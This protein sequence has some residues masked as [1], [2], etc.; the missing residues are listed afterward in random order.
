MQMA[1]LPSILTLI[2]RKRMM[3]FYLLIL[4]L[5]CTKME[6]VDMSEQKRD[7][8]SRTLTNAQIVFKDSGFIKINLRS[9]LIEEYALIDSPYTQF[10]KGLEMNFYSNNI[11]S[12][13]Y[14]RANWA[15]MNELK[16]WYEGRG[17]VK[18]I[19]EKGNRKSVV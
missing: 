5:G 16:E 6:D 19:S 8:P 18:I 17:D 2:C 9:P 13:G 3:P 12:P 4:I 7:F 14:L 10:P 11:D 1:R 15:V